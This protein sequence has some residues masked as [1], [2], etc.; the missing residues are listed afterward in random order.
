MKLL[1]LVQLRPI[2][3]L[4]VSMIFLKS[5]QLNNA[6]TK[7]AKDLC[8]KHVQNCNLVLYAQDKLFKSKTFSVPIVV[9]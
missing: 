3:A 1:V 6:V 4:Y 7:N 2:L 8:A 5:K 9:N